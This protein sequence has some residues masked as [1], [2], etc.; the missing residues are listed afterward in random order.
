MQLSV[1]C[2]HNNNTVCCA[3]LCSLF[4]FHDLFFWCRDIFFCFINSEFGTIAE[5]AERLLN[6]F[7]GIKKLDSNSTLQAFQKWTFSFRKKKMYNK[8]NRTSDVSGHVFIRCHIEFVCYMK[9]E[10]AYEKTYMYMYFFVR[11]FILSLTYRV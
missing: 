7:H 5:C 3:V 10:K 8:I 6:T 2:K 1:G 9:H 4:K 11:F